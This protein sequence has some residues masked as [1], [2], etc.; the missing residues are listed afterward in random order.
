MCLRFLCLMMRTGAEYGKKIRLLRATS[1]GSPSTEYSSLL[2][3]IPMAF[4]VVISGK[5][6]SMYLARFFLRSLVYL[7]DV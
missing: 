5:S 4:F 2:F 1:F 7:F 3:L 6:T